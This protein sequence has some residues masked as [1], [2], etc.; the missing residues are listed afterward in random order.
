MN[1]C[2]DPRTAT[3]TSVSIVPLDRAANCLEWQHLAPTPHI[4][5]AFKFVD[6]FADENRKFGGG[7]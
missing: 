7:L 6:S 2:G 1:G 5:S 4:L 3:L